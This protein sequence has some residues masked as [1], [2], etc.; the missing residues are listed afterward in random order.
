M[1]SVPLGAQI[2]AIGNLMNPIGGVWSI[3]HNTPK[4]MTV[5]MPFLRGSVTVM[6]DVNGI[7]HIYAQ[8]ESDAYATMGY[9]EAHDRM[10][11]LE[12]ER[13]EISGLLS[14]LVGSEALP[15]DE[16]YRN[17]RLHSAGVNL[18]RY[19]EATD[20]ALYQL[21][22]NY[23]AGINYVISTTTDLPLEFHLLGFEPSPWTV[24]DVLAV[25]KLMDEQLTFNYDDIQQTLLNQTL[26]NQG[27][28]AALKELYPRVTPFQKPITVDY[29]HYTGAGGENLISPFASDQFASN[30]VSLMDWMQYAQQNSPIPAF[31]GYG[32]NNW[33]VSSAKSA[34]G[35]P[36]LCNDPHLG[37]SLPM[38]WY[39]AQMVAADTNLDVQGFALPGTPFIV[40]GHNENVA[41][42]F[43]NAG[44]DH[45][46]WYQ[47]KTNGTSYLYNGSMT[48]FKMVTEE[49]P[50]KGQDDVS[51]TIKST[52]DGVVIMAPDPRNGPVQYENATGVAI[53]FK[54]VA[55]V[56]NT[57][58]YS[59]IY[60]FDHAI[61][62]ADFNTALAK[63]SMPSQNIIYGD[64]W[65]DIAI[66]CTGLVPIRYGVT[67]AS[68]ACRFL[69]NG[70]S[71]EHGW[72]GQFIPFADLPH[73]VNPSQGYLA[74]ANQLSA[75]PAY[76]YYFQDTMDS[77]YRARRINDL[78]ASI[79]KVS[80]ADMARIQFDVYDKSA[81]WF[82][83]QI[84]EVFTN[85][86][87]FP[88]PQKTALIN[89]SIAILQAWN[90]SSNPNQYRMYANMSA[91]AI[92]QAIIDYYMKDTFDEFAPIATTPGFQYPDI[93]V[94][95]NLTLNKPN[96]KWFYTGAN[97][98]TCHDV[99]RQAIKDAI[100]WLS[101]N[102]SYSTITDPT[103]WLY[104]MAHKVAWYHLTSLV[105][106]SVG[107]LPG[108]GS[109]F[110]VDPSYAPLFGTATWGASFRMIIDMSQANHEFNTSRIVIPGG[111][112]GDPA[113]PHYT[114]Q[115][116]L[117][118]KGDYVPVYF[119]ATESEFTAPEFEANWTF[120][121][122]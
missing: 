44:C 56:V 63:F 82:V 41:W 70:S 107:P 45:I 78:L 64:K 108:N 32:S 65:G 16:F 53:G 42:G 91:P 104:G 18:S 71:G 118:L 6:K 23:T 29:G 2:P 89:Q 103:G 122:S 20:P 49:I 37:W 25:E 24:G 51:F 12:M 111:E 81:A 38:I 57:T 113:S 84:L 47:Y 36:I 43:T 86:T 101:T 1:L 97:H 69:L 5:E 33:V 50:V 100:S 119:H 99:I 72:T 27:Y 80:V 34:T 121:R 46:D 39:E 98:T 59:A 109:G 88:S 77:G 21:I 114:D 73:S 14:Q 54:W 17:I 48:P 19:V 79:P 26:V 3:D 112:S 35:K 28:G 75:G 7:P 11:Q 68:N 67:N 105:P 30:L 60:G 13:R 96:S 15:L 74:S 120:Y 31:E 4:T 85:K 116:Q 62:L 66:R 76:S 92:F 40:I 83:P 58:T 110:T 61:D 106:L 8:Y 95:E 90:D 93:T 55:I 102:T 52:D 10:F 94:L 9:L 87:E 22:G 117:Y 115:L